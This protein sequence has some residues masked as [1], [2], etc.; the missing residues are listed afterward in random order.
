MLDFVT[1]FEFIAGTA[2]GVAFAIP[3]KAAWN[4]GKALY[5]N[6]RKTSN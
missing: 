3:L 2:F 4:R 5:Q 6:W 1:S